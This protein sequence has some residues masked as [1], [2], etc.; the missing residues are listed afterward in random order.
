[1]VIDTNPTI[2]PILDLTQVRKQAGE[3]TDLTANPKITAGV[4][5]AQA[6][7]IALATPDDKTLAALGGTAVHFE[8]NINS[9]KALSEIEIYRHTRNQLSQFKTALALR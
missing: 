4:S 3:L 7:N 6:S 1:M 5:S 8:Q 2:T 9:P